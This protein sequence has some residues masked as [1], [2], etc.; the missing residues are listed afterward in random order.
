MLTWQTRMRLCSSRVKSAIRNAGGVASVE[1]ISLIQ[2]I[3]L[4][5]TDLPV[6][7]SAPGRDSAPHE[8]FKPHLRTRRK[9]PSGDVLFATNR[10]GSI[11]LTGTVE[12]SYSN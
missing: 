3:V 12:S 9:S 2:L 6:A 5:E 8:D 4:R 7:E 10:H 11:H 1:V